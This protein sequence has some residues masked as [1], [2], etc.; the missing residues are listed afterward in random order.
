MQK[1]V[2]H[3]CNVFFHHICVI[4][5]PKRIQKSKLLPYK[6]LLS[7]FCGTDLS[8][9]HS[10]CTCYSVEYLVI[11]CF[12]S[13]ILLFVVLIFCCCNLFLLSLIINSCEL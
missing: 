2:L 13:V 12:S 6:C 8:V 10:R 11:M 5:R 9:D 4:D 3:N 7:I 1:C